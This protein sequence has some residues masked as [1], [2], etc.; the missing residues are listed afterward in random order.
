MM[1]SAPRVHVGGKLLASGSLGANNGGTV[2]ILYGCERTGQGGIVAG[3]LIER[4]VPD[5]A[6]P[7]I[8]A[9]PVS[10]TRCQGESADF[11]VVAVGGGALSYQWLRNA[12]E[13]AGANGA[14]FTTPPLSGSDSGSVFSVRVSNQCGTVTSVGAT[15]SVIV[16]PSITSQ[17]IPAEQCE[18]Q[19][20]RF[21]VGV[22]GTGPLSYQWQFNE[23]DLPGQTGPCLDLSAIRDAQAG[24]YRCRIS[25]SCGSVVSLPA[26][27]TVFTPPRFVLD[28]TSV[29]TCPGQQV[30]LCTSGTGTPPFQYQWL[31]DG[32]DIPGATSFCF[33]TE[34]LPAGTPTANYSVRV[35]NRCGSTTSPSTPV[36]VLPLPVI[37]RQP[38]TI[39]TSL[40]S[41]VKFCVEATGNPPLRVQWLKDGVAIPGA[42]SACFE[43][44]QASLEDQGSYVAQVSDACTTISSAPASLRLIDIHGSISGYVWNDLNTNGVRDGYITGDRPNVIFI[45]D[46]SSSTL[47]SFVGTPVGDVNADGRANTILDAEIKAFVGL[48]QFLVNRGFGETGR[49]SVVAFDALARTLDFSAAAGLQ[50]W[51]NPSHDTDGH[52]A[53]DVEEALVGLR[54]SGGTNFEDALANA[55]KLLTDAGVSNSA[56]IVF[57]SD[58]KP[59]AGGDYTAVVR[60]L[61]LRGVSLRAFGVGAGASLPELQAI[62]PD[63]KVFTNMDEL[64]TVFSGLNPGAVAAEPALPFV[65]VYLDINNNREYDDQEPFA[66]SDANGFYRF[67]VTNTIAAGSLAVYVRQVVQ[68]GYFEVAPGLRGD[69]FVVLSPQHPDATIHFGSKATD[70]FLLVANPNS[71]APY[72]L[73]YLFGSHAELQFGADIGKPFKVWATSDFK[74]W[75]FV[76]NYIGTNTAVTIRDFHPI[77]TSVPGSRMFY[78]V[79]GN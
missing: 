14:C 37:T 8:V 28:R 35:S 3:Q 32:V 24:S 67:S 40:G 68:P 47:D 33:A 12:Q 66:V 4:H 18:G 64:I 75:R 74:T 44:G 46:R 76:G 48:N 61:R 17:P 34:H 49:V 50:P 39:E 10:V 15:A 55:L 13:I 79:H 6:I 22:A 63:A 77:N 73:P 60:A 19:S 11:C 72:R 42:N 23:I 38:T 45:L 26:L 53:L 54:A 27:L 70:K 36:R 41:G 78:S 59:T 30:L 20:A 29:E 56:S 51:V 1:L 52:G 62:D 71:Q 9:S 21:C 7:T 58:G 16:P 65:P 57:L 31:K 2:Q 69:H 5:L 25:N 43:L